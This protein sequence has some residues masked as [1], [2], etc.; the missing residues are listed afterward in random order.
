MNREVIHKNSSALG[1]DVGV[2]DR[3]FR[4]RRG[5]GAPGIHVYEDDS[6]RLLTYSSREQESWVLN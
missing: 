5:T 2:G 6:T 3:Y 1:A 4:V